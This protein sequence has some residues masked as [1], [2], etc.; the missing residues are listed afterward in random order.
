MDKHNFIEATVYLFHFLKQKEPA[1][2]VLI[3]FQGGCLMKKLLA[4]LLAALMVFGLFNAPVFADN[5]TGETQKVAIVKQTGIAGV[6][7]DGELITGSSADLTPG[8]HTAV[9]I[10]EDGYAFTQWRIGFQ[11][12]TEPELIF[13]V[14][15]VTRIT[16]S[17]SVAIT[18]YRLV[19]DEWKPFDIRPAQKSGQ[20]TL[21]KEATP[22]MNLKEWN[23]A[24]DGS[25]TPYTPGKSIKITEPLSLY[26]QEEPIDVMR[27]LRINVGKGVSK[28]GVTINGESHFAMD[29][30]VGSTVTI[31]AFP[32]NPDDYE[33][34]SW[35]SVDYVYSGVTYVA[36]EFDGTE[37]APNTFEFT[38]PNENTAIQV[39][40]S[41]IGER[42]VYIIP[43]ETIKSVSGAGTY[44]IGGENRPQLSA[45]PAAGYGTVYWKSVRKTVDGIACVRSMQHDAYGDEYE[46]DMPAY[47]LAFE[48]TAKPADHTVTYIVDDAEW[49]S[50]GFNTGA[51]ITAVRFSPQKDGMTFIEWNT[52]ADGSGASYAPGESMILAGDTTLYAIYEETNKDYY[53]SVNKNGLGIQSVSGYSGQF[54]KGD[55]VT[56]TA[57]VKDGFENP[58]WTPT[59]RTLNGREYYDRGV[60]AQTG[61]VCTFTMPAN[62]VAFDLTAQRKLYPLY[63]DVQAGVSYDGERFRYVPAGTSVT[64]S[65]EPEAGYSN[66]VWKSV[67]GEFDGITYKS[68]LLFSG[69]NSYTFTMPKSPVAL[70]V[71]AKQRLFTITWK[72]STT[73]LEVD[74]GMA[75]GTTPTY[76][77]AVPTKPADAQ[78]TYTFDGWTVNADG[79]GRIYSTEELPAVS[80]SATYYAHFATAVNKYTIR[81][82]NDATE[83]YSGAFAYDTKPVYIGVSP[84]KDPAG[85]VSYIFDGWTANPDG[86]GTVY[87]QA[88][89]PAV[90]GEA[91]YYAHFEGHVTAAILHTI[92]F[93]N[94]STELQRDEIADNE[95][96]VYEGSI[97]VKGADAQYTYTFNGWTVNPDGTGTVYTSE[98]LP[99]ATSDAIYYAHYNMSVNDYDITFINGTFI[100]QVGQFPY[101]VQPFYGGNTPTKTGDAQY[102]YTFDGWTVNA[103]GSG[104][105][106]TPSALPLVTGSATYYAH[107][108]DL[109]N[110]YNVKFMNGSIELQSGDMAYN[111]QPVYNGAEP[112]KTSTV[113]YSYTFNGWTVNADGSGTVYTTSTLPLVSGDATYY[114][115]F[116]SSVRRYQITWK[117]WDGSVLAT[118]SVKYDDTPVYSGETPVRPDD[119]QYS[120]TFADDWTPAITPVAGPATYVAKFTET[121]LPITYTVT[122]K[123]WNGAV[124]EIDHNVPSGANPSYD[125]TTPTRAEDAN[126]TYTFAA[127]S[128]TPTVVAADATY[129]ATFTPHP[130]ANTSYRVW[131]ENA[132]TVGAI[133]GSG[134][135]TPGETVTLTATPKTETRYLVGG[136]LGICGKKFDSSVNTLEQVESLPAASS[137][138][139]NYTQSPSSC[140][141]WST[142]PSQDAHFTWTSVSV[143]GAAAD[144]GDIAVYSSMNHVGRTYSF[145]MPAH[146]L[147]FRCTGTNHSF[148]TKSTSGTFAANQGITRRCSLCGYEHEF[149]ALTGPYVAALETGV[150][151]AYLAFGEVSEVFDT[152]NPNGGAAKT[153]MVPRGAYVQLYAPIPIHSGSRWEPQS[154]T[155]TF[156][157][158]Y[159]ITFSTDD[160]YS[161]HVYNSAISDIGADY[162]TLFPDGITTAAG[163]R[164]TY[165]AMPG[166]H[167]C[168]DWETAG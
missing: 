8:Q 156:S 74:T 73:T 89:L 105:V 88:T 79:T 59:T 136:L 85:N 132:G 19:N 53:V 7:I 164:Y 125:G 116:V 39:S 95:R 77:S 48:V 37:P 55:T 152:Y 162:P 71:T 40:T 87:T 138:V 36:S 11:T 3:Y 120:Y 153:K 82:M 101:N 65:A 28:S 84:Q 167:Y 24:E 57:T 27:K 16:V 60:T 56:I 18:Y 30:K 47:H 149:F 137:S 151:L 168:F 10:P 141:V 86:S 112:T 43:D 150:R 106:Y 21:L 118:D 45:T 83:L 41:R 108:V 22:G 111:A 15:T 51:S 97:P 130:K 124:L 49:K 160:A 25:G 58:I 92:V 4:F 99:T 46:F 1:L 154:G 67:A 155:V 81:F 126:N 129:F 64:V 63:I 158:P 145:T 147:A 122:W 61:Y 17:G 102:T 104:T 12:K 143:S 115:H 20:I 31:T 135:Y 6:E 157:G 127:W 69:S 44:A 119:N 134:Y 14:P 5:A 23:T 76:T 146:D 62:N 159:T 110:Q 50:V 117:N 121:P 32:S 66:I 103:D 123:N 107:F 113:Q 29:I 9:A 70:R 72:N 68:A 78:Y 165:M 100:L 90:T 166:R 91:V 163:M 140:L 144:G 96:P 34:S 133:S 139:A 38:M 161:V 75:P 35:A 128:P 114:A 148:V 13:D 26:A 33:I 94:G 142:C 131:T 80:G 98:T 54:K 42:N 109:T 52:V 2:L 93:M